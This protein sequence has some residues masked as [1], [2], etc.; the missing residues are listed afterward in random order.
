MKGPFIIS[1]KLLYQYKLRLVP[2]YPSQSSLELQLRALS[3]SMHCTIANHY[4]IQFKVKMYSN[5]QYIIKW[6]NKTKNLRH[7]FIWNPQLYQNAN[8]MKC[9]CKI[10][11]FFRK[12]QVLIFFSNISVKIERRFVYFSDKISTFWQWTN[13]IIF[14]KFIGIT[15]ILLIVFKY[16]AH[17]LTPCSARADFQY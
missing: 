5:P 2:F 16:F 6:C 8:K 15:F 17:L 10:H 13:S 12:I 14:H 4:T 7:H 11:N 3:S 9:L 1:W